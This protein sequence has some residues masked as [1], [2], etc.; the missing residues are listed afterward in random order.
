MGKP[1]PSKPRQDEVLRAYP[2][3]GVPGLS[4][5]RG[6]HC[7]HGGHVALTA[8]QTTSLVALGALIGAKGL[9]LGA[10]LASR[11]RGKGDVSE[12]EK[13][14]GALLNI[15][16]VAALEPEECFKMVF[17][18]AATGR[19]NNAE[20]ESSLQ[21]VRDAMLLEPQSPYTQKY[22]AAA[23]FGASRQDIGKCEHHYKCS[24]PVHLLQ[25]IFQ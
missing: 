15:E 10:L 13:V 5:D 2:P 9:L 19:L 14:D 25:E 6:H 17:C 23:Y 3:G 24:L 18:S 22:R 7:P 1:F 20:L 4:R 8:A 12:L 21:V 11:R 16:M